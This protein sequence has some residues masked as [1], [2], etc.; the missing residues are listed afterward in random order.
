[1]NIEPI[2]AEEAKGRMD[3]GE[4]V[5]FLDARNEDAWRTSEWQIPDSRRLPPED[6]EAHLDEVPLADLIVPYAT[7]TEDASHV[8]RRLAEYGWPNVRPL[9]GGQEVWHAAGY[10]TESTP[11]RKLTLGEA[12]SNLQ[13]AEGD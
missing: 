5:V 2:T 13:K 11:A 12:S 4:A 3:A 9:L 6:V 10:P 1:M 7:S 8:A